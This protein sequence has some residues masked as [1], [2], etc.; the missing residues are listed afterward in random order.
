MPK[1]RFEAI[2]EK[3]RIV[4]IDYAHTPDALE[5]ICRATKEACPGRRLITVFGCG[6]DRDKTK[7]P[8]M[9]KAASDYSD[10]IIVTSD[11]PRSEEPAEII[12]SIVMGIRGNEYIIEEDRECAIALAINE[13][14]ER[15]VVIIAGKGHEEYQEIKGHKKKFSDVE[16]AQKYLR[17]L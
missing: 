16:M 7:R 10:K 8:L 17:E 12:K 14:C 2:E 1:G 11:N 4:I 13:S 15:D 9:G 5:N 3:N 6:G